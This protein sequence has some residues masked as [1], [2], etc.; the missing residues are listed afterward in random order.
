MTR[1]KTTL[2]H[3]DGHEVEVPADAV[4]TFIAKGFKKKSNGIKKVKD[5]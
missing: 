3:P 5:K 4:E 1:K 2:N